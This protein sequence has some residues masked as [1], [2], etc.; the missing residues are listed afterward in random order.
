MLFFQLFNIKPY[1]VINLFKTNL[2]VRFGPFCVI[3]RD[4]SYFNW[5]W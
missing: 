2:D 1:K 5:F 3:L 4:Y